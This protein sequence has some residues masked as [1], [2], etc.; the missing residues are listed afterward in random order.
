MSVSELINGPRSKI[1]LHIRKAHVEVD[2][3]KIRSS[4]D[5]I[6]Q[7]PKKYSVRPNSFSS[8][9]LIF[10]SL[11]T[12]PINN[13]DLG[14]GTPVRCRLRRD[15]TFG[16]TVVVLREPNGDGFE[17]CISLSGDHIQKLEQDPEFKM[18]RSLAKL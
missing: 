17:A 9:A 4:I 18:F 10:T 5:W 3:S 11:T 1:A 16:G 14:Y 8:N 13:L 6:E 15:I 7:H 12:F 2:E